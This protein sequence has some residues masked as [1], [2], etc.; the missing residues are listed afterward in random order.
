VVITDVHFKEV[1]NHTPALQE[2]NTAEQCITCL[3]FFDIVRQIH[4]CILGQPKYEP[5]IRNAKQHIE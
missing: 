2:E 3:R 4:V 1:V 5:P